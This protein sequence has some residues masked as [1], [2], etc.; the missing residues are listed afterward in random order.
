MLSP[1]LGQLPHLSRTLYNMEREEPG[2]V[3]GRGFLH[4]GGRSGPEKRG[5]SGPE[6]E[7]HES[8]DIGEG[9]QDLGIP[10]GLEGDLHLPAAQES[11]HHRV[12]GALRVGAELGCRCADP[13]RVPQQH[14]V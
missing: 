13:G 7:T 12:Q 4:I 3:Q 11:G 8:Q 10:D 2:R 6:G 9:R 14:P 5:S 1:E